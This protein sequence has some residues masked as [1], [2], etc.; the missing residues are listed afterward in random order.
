[1]DIDGTD[2][3][4]EFKKTPADGSLKDVVRDDNI[5]M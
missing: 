4:A 2:T 1:M 3:Y 5:D